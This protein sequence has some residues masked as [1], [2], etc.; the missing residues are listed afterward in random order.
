[1]TD[2]LTL[3]IGITLWVFVLVILPKWIEKA[4]LKA[5]E[6]AKLPYKQR[7][8]RNERI[9]NV[10]YKRIKK[11]IWKALKPSLI[12]ILKLFG[13]AILF[14]ILCL[15]ASYDFYYND[16]INGWLVISIYIWVILSHRSDKV[17]YKAWQEKAKYSEFDK[18]FCELWRPSLIGYLFAFWIG[19]KFCNNFEFILIMLTANCY[20]LWTR[21]YLTNNIKNDLILEELQKNWQKDSQYY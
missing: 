7:F 11:R 2:L 1:M 4:N 15:L 13:W 18:R 12:F 9:F 10:R 21:R 17:N 14:A 5:E 3:L 20:D 16:N 8:S 19:L 6:T